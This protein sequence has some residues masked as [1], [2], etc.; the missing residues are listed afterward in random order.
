METLE[1][2]GQGIEPLVRREGK[3]KNTNSLSESLDCTAISR[4]DLGQGL[5]LSV[6]QSL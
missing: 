6:T 5:L 3:G 1:Q 2:D 4:G